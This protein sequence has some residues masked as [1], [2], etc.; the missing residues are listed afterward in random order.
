MAARKT[1]NVPIM[2][3]HLHPD[4]DPI[5]KKVLN[6]LKKQRDVSPSELPIIATYANQVFLNQRAMMSMVD[7]GVVLTS[8]TNHG[9]VHKEN[10]QCKVFNQTT[11]QIAKYAVI[12]GLSAKAGDELSTPDE[13]GDEEDDPLSNLIKKRGKK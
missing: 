13:E 1:T 9:E 3:F 11:I 8:T 4:V 2:L 5:Y 12:L 6:V 10:P 7:D